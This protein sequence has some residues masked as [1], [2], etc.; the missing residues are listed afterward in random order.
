MAAR[1]YATE[2]QL[3]AYGAP[4]GTVLPTGAEAT[5]QL[6][7]ASERIDELLLTAVYATDINALPTDANILDA[8]QKAVCAQV[9][10]WGETGDEFGVGELFNNVSIGRVSMSRA[11]KSSGAGSGHASARY[12]PQAITHL[13]LARDANGQTLIPGSVLHA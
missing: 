9:L 13:R 3:I 2:A 1:V 12:A 5:R 11:T 7:R 6:T 10:W 4:T 8:F